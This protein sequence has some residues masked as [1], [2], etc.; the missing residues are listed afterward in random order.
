MA[1]QQCSELLPSF[2]H[3]PH[4][5]PGRAGST[6]CRSRW[7]QGT[8]KQGEPPQK[9]PIL[10]LSRGQADPNGTWPVD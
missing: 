2:V 7:W 6:G 4:C 5:S 8:N 9:N 3:F 10:G 1:E